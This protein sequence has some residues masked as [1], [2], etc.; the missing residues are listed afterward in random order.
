MN[1]AELSIKNI[2][3][4]GLYG[5]FFLVPAEGWLADLIKVLVAGSDTDLIHSQNKNH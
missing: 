5:P 3:N 2:R 1:R 4:L